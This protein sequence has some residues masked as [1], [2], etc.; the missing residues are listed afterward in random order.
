MDM[1]AREACR[2][3]T[4]FN[5]GIAFV[6]E[7]GEEE[8]VVRWALGG[9]RGVPAGCADAR[10]LEA[11][12]NWCSSTPLEAFLGSLTR[13]RGAAQLSAK[14]NVLLHVT[15]VAFVRVCQRM[16]LP[17]TELTPRGIIHNRKTVT[18]R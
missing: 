9:C 1:S 7:Q 10:R 17:W 11:S 15:L 2:R 6:T 18:Q 4:K 16:P 3:A 14:Y 12:Q 8:E 13:R 5:R